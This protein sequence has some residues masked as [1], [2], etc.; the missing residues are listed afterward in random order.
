MVGITMRTSP[1]QEMSHGYAYHGYAY[2]YGYAYTYLAPAEDERRE[3][4]HGRAAAHVA[5][6]GEAA[7]VVRG[8]P[9]EEG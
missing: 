2:Y 4:W 7:V 9:G 6:R 3:R 5:P 1:P 8:V